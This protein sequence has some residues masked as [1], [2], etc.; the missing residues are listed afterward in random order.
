[1]VI[2]TLVNQAGGWPCTNEEPS[3]PIS[4]QIIQFS[5]HASLYGYGM[6]MDY[7]FT[8]YWCFID[9]SMF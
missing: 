6:A 1:M 9:I 4:Y 2:V 7:L 5:Q 3:L 8:F